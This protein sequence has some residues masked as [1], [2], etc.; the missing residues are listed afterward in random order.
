[1]RLPNRAF[2]NRAADVSWYV[3][4]IASAGTA[5]AIFALMVRNAVEGKCVG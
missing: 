4:L 1:M 3:V 5:L 2:W